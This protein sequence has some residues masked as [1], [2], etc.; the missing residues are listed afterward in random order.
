M[1]L[2]EREEKWRASKQSLLWAPGRAWGFLYRWHDN[3][4]ANGTA[5]PIVSLIVCRRPS[6]LQAFLIWGPIFLTD[7]ASE[8]FILPAGHMQNDGSLVKVNK[9]LLYPCQIIHADIELSS[10]GS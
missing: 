7:W 4:S 6:Q 10:K 5:S 3:L 2:T 1:M 8:R 9:M